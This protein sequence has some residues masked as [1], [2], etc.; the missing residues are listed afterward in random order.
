MPFCSL[1]GTIPLAGHSLSVPPGSLVMAQAPP[2]PRD[3]ERIARM[4]A[5]SHEAFRQLV[6]EHQQRVMGYCTRFLGDPALAADVTQEVFV[7]FWKQ[8][9]DYEERGALRLYLL[10]IARLRCLAAAKRRRSQRGLV[11][12]LAEQVPRAVGSPA[13]RTE[14]AALV[15]RGLR[16]VPPKFADVLVLR[17]L[18]ELELS[19]I[20]TV[21]GLRLGTVKSRLGRGLKRLREEIGDA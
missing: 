10:T 20:A 6:E 14:A 11:E 8:R 5:G 3:S 2:R 21:T 1:S 16:A 12:A 17:Y 7:T 9:A 19:E 18:E 13:A 15:R 4:K